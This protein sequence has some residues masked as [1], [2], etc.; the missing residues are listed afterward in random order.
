M[1]IDGNADAA[2]TENAPTESAPTTQTQTQAPSS[3][4]SGQ[5]SIEPWYSS[6]PDDLKNDPNVTKY[7]KL[8]E[9]IKGGLSAQKLIGNSV[10]VP[11]DDATPDEWAKF[12]EKTG[13]PKTP[14]E[15]NPKIKTVTNEAGE[16][17]P[18]F[19][20]DQESFSIAKQQFHKLGLRPDQ[21]QGVMDLYA[22]QRIAE[23][24]QGNTD[25]QA[26]Q[27]QQRQETESQ[28]KK[29]WG[30]KYDINMSIVNKT[31]S[32]FGILDEIKN[33][34]LGNSAGV[35]KMFHELSRHISESTLTGDYTDAGGGFEERVAELKSRPAY[36]DRTHAQHAEVN[37]KVIELYAQR[38]PNK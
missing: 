16:E 26:Y 9:A 27:V 35:I 11:G 3:A 31:V 24:S 14:D 1:L 10:R 36:S 4:P 18:V 37:K 13:R 22:E 25:L 29:E 8:D 19:E 20:L 23:F 34:G 38:Y 30:D 33:L 6:L 12:Y 17:I 5:Q 21:V 28:L 15:Y 32:K 7:S 2:P